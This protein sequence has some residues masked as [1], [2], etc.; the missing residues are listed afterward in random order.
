M[1]IQKFPLAET[2][3]RIS[4]EI[5]KANRMAIQRG[6][7]MQFEECEIE[8]GFEI[9]KE[10]NT[11]LDIKIFNFGGSIKKSDTNTVKIKY[12]SIKGS[13]KVAAAIASEDEIQQPSR[14][15]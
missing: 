9:E 15:K 11:G 10:G 8:F 13:A 3:L 7:V 4:A 2:L 14:R 12:K 5:E 6:E 1:E